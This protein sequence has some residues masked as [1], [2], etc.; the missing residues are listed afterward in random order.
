MDAGIAHRYNQIECTDRCGQ[1]IQVILR[2]DAGKRVQRR[3]RPPAGFDFGLAV[4]VFERDELGT[5][6]S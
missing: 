3:S 5:G 1:F 6:R 2:V 4:A